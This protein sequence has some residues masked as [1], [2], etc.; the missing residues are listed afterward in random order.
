MKGADY[1][2]GRARLCYNNLILFASPVSEGGLVGRGCCVVGGR[3]PLVCSP[4]FSFP[5]VGKKL[6]RAGFLMNPAK[7]HCDLPSE[8][9]KDKRA[10]ASLIS[11]HK[12]LFV[13]SRIVFFLYAYIFIYTKRD[14]FIF[15]KR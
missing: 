4:C 15:G 14:F 9:E 8:T 7:V 1:K 5:L 12:H 13:T 6:C 10:V 2:H 11:M 3:K